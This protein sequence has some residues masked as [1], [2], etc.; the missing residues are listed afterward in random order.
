MHPK[1]QM[2]SVGFLHHAFHDHKSQNMKPTEGLIMGEQGKCD[3]MRKP[4]NLFVTEQTN[5]E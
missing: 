3:T 4:H 1:K 5:L 2:L